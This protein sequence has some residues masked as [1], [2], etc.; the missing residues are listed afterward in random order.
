MH[1][2]CCFI[3]WLSK[4]GEELV[5]GYLNDFHIGLDYF[6]ISFVVGFIRNKDFGIEF[7]SRTDTDNTV[8][9]IGVVV[10]TVTIY[11]PSVVRIVGIGRTKPQN[12]QSIPQNIS[13]RRPL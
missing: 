3:V 7:Q 1:H 12:K 9:R 6:V 5:L 4:D 13:K 10:I 11:I 8:I 2:R